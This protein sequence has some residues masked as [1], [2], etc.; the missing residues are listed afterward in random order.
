MP[1]RKRH[2]FLDGFNSN[3]EFRSRRTG[4]NPITPPQDRASH[5]SALA[6]RYTAILDE[7]VRR[8]QVR[9]P[10]NVTANSGAT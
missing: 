5:G 3:E 10:V 7:S 2:L 6:H 8:R 4:R 9:I 1:D